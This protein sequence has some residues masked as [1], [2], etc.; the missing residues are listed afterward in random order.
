MVNPGDI[1]GLKTTDFF[2]KPGG[3][4]APTDQSRVNVTALNPDVDED[5]ASDGDRFVE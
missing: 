1:R 3:V 2:E 5:T 4:Q